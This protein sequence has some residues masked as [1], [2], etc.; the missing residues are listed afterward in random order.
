MLEPEKQALVSSA[1]E[2]REK[3]AK[4]IMVPMEEV[5]SVSSSVS[6][7]ELVKL[8]KESNYSRLPVYE[9]KKENAKSK[10]VEIL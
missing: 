7:E 2:F 8:L 3:L 1:M 6:T 9:G 4:N 10:K 5:V